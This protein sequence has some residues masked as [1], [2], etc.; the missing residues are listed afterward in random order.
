M[1][2]TLKSLALLNFKGARNLQVE[3]GRQ[4]TVISG[5][6]GTGK[7]T[8]FDAVTWL[9]FDKDSTGASK[10]NLKTLDGN[11][12]VIEKIEHEVVGV[13][14]TGYEDVTLKKVLREKW[15]KKKGALEPEF[16]GNEVLY[17]CNDVPLKESEYKMKVD[18]MLKEDLFKLVTSPYYFNTLKWQDRRNVLTKMAGNV[19][20]A[21]IA[22]Q[23]PEF[24]ELLTL[25]GRKSFDEYKR[26]IASRKKKLNDDL[27][28]IPTRVDELMRSIPQGIDFETVAF[29]VGEYEKQIKSLDEQITDKGKLLETFYSDKQKKQEQLSQLNGQKLKFE[30]EANIEAARQNN[31]QNKGAEEIASD[32]RTLE[33]VIANATEELKR[34]ERDRDAKADRRT[35]LEGQLN[36]LRE[37][38]EAEN[39]KVLNWGENDFVCPCCHRP[40]EAE[41]IEAKKAEMLKNFNESKDKRLDEIDQQGV[42]RKT[43]LEGLNQRIEVLTKDVFQISSEQDIRRKQLVSLKEKLGLE[44]K[45]VKLVTATGL[46]AS[47]LEY[48]K[49]KNQIEDLKEEIEQMKPNVDT[50]ELKAKKG[51]IQNLLEESKNKLGVKDQIERTEQRISELKGEEK[52]LSQQI[53]NLEKSEFV[54]Q[55]FTKAKIDTIEARINGMFSLVKFKMFETQ[56]NGGESETC[57]CTI[58]GVPYSDLNTASKINAGLDIINALCNFYQVSA[59]IFIDGRESINDI[60]RV[61]SQIVNLVVSKEP[62]QVTQIN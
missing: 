10:F 23:K 3:F 14:D 47:N 15:Q 51:N 35:L 40:F 62:F 60:L 45:D 18:S 48:I 46:L 36:Q 53:A 29:E 13:F 1:K 55:E 19:S 38:W 4:E 37:D 6:N 34:V 27:K 39:A 30:Q 33:G 61:Q 32:I 8:I 49:L 31:L 22:T 26:E 56:I 7:T 5:E 44:N 43:E 12:K 52:N 17:Y 41:N 54:M 21:E 42:E 58:N 16:T 24:A 2:I 50:S 25:I 9:L 11:N 57:E 20:D 28:T 59:P